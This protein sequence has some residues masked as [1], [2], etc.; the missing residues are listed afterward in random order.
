MN[1]KDAY[2]YENIIH[3]A[4]GMDNK[5]D[6]VVG[7]V[8]LAIAIACKDTQERNEKKNFP[9]CT[10]CILSLSCHEMY[11]FCNYHGMYFKCQKTEE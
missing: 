4:N 11:N 9:K 10:D 1:G 6:A 8:G 7:L 5:E 2:L 3:L